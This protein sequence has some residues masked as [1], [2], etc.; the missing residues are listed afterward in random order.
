MQLTILRPR[1]LRL[2]LMST[3]V[4]GSVILPAWVSAQ[5]NFNIDVGLPGGEGDPQQHIGKLIVDVINIMLSFAAVLAVGAIIW[6]A[7]MLILSIGEDKR[8]QTAKKIIFSAIIGLLIVGL[9]FLIVRFVG[10]FLDAGGAA[11]PAGQPQQQNQPPPQPPQ[12]AGPGAPVRPDPNLIL[13]GGQP[14]PNNV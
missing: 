13:P 4:V 11:V 6:G 12:P 7:V 3:L 5:P 14:D 1:S 8:V 9:S 10:Q 2:I